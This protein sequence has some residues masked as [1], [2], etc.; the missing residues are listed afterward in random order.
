MLS[1]QAA[2]GGGVG[3]VGPWTW[4]TLCPGPFSGEG[5]VKIHWQQHLGQQR[6]GTVIRKEDQGGHQ[7]IHDNSVLRTEKRSLSEPLLSVSPE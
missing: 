6:M 2:P 3:I 1:V 5:P 7:H 4:H